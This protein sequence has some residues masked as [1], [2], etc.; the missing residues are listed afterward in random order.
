MQ[1]DTVYRK[2]QILIDHR[3]V[4]KIK[5]IKQLENVYASINRNHDLIRLFIH[6]AVVSLSC[7]TYGTLPPIQRLMV[8]FL[9][10]PCVYQKHLFQ[11]FLALGG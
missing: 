1:L 11:K 5:K 7:Y 4:E 3:E 8:C 6:P 9:R 10:Q 2:I